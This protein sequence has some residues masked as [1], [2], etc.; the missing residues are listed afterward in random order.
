MKN[1]RVRVQSAQEQWSVDNI[2]SMVGSDASGRFG[3][4]AEHE[5][6]ITSLQPGLIRLCD[7]SGHWFYLAQPGGVLVFQ[8][9]QL[10][11]AC[12]EFM[13]GDDAELLLTKLEKNWQQQDQDLH[14]AKSSIV[15]VEQTLA[16]KLWQMNRQGLM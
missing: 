13:H 1:F 6:F 10:N 7:D 8:D 3:L 12:T 4:Q 11:I 2:V 15:Q 16:R 14:K 9:G 5:Y